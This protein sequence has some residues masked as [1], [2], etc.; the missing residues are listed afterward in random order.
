MRKVNISESL[1]PRLS[2]DS[3]FFVLFIKCISLFVSCLMPL[4]L[5]DVCMASNDIVIAG[6]ALILCAHE[7]TSD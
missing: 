4:E 3:F 7:N 5:A 6:G 1:R 2:S